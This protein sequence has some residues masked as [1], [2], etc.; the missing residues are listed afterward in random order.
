MSPNWVLKA[1]YP[2]SQGKQPGIGS[3]DTPTLAVW[4]SNSARIKTL[5]SMVESP[6]IAQGDRRKWEMELM[7]PY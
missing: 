1:A 4:K 3:K 2:A 6:Y 5:N 7:F